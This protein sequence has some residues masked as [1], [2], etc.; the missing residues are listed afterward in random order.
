MLAGV[1]TAC[2]YPKPT[3]DSLT[4]LGEMGVKACELFINS[5]LELEPSFLRGLRDIAEFYGIKIVALH[6]CTGVI[7]P[8]VFFSTYQRRF[9][10]GLELFKRYYEASAYL[11]AELMVFHGNNRSYLFEHGAYFE[12]FDILHREAAKFGIELCQENVARCDSHSIEFLQDMAANLPD[13]RFVFDLKQAIRA[14]YTIEQFAEAILPRIA[15]IHLS[16]HNDSLDCLLPWRGSFNISKFLAG[17]ANSGINP[18]VI[19]EVYSNNFTDYV[20]ISA[21]YQRLCT[22]LSTFG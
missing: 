4:A 1:S 9:D 17:I 14:E 13:C 8:F 20:E 15:H 12:R 5:T 18:A 10:E 7:E 22:E 2:F 19:V 21:S 3:E 11:G 16:D 6:P